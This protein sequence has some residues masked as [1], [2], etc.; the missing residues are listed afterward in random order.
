LIPSITTGLT[1][2]ITP[3]K[4]PPPNSK[5]IF[6]FAIAGPLAGLAL[7]LVLLLSGLDMTTT[8]AMNSQLPVVPVDL[9]R[10]SSLGGGL[11]QYFLGT[12]AIMPDQGPTAVVQLHPLAIAGVVGCIT[13]ALALLPLGRTYFTF[14]FLFFHG[15][16]LTFMF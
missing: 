2:A 10:S 14:L 15:Q 1:G 12:T 4:S 16:L 6:D 11:V 13:N 3:L 8:M 5:A 7:S 9:V